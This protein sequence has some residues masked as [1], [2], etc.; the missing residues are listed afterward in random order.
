MPQGN[1]LYSYLKQTKMSFFFFYII[2]KPE[3]RTG[4]IWG[5]GT[6]RRG[7]MLGKGVGG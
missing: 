1:S 3:G 7:R 5:I 2:G 4:P 6:S